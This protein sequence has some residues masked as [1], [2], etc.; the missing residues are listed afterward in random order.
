MYT[1]EKPFVTSNGVEVTD[2]MFDKWAEG[3]ES[4]NWPGTATVI[5]GRP[6]L[7]EEE[8][9]PV[10]FKLP[11]SKIRALDK[12]AAQLGRSRSAAL[13]EAVSEYLAHA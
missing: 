1:K 12:R 8:I 10:T 5:L 13:R 4:G 7:T 6:R 2:D 11:L 3:F 9:K